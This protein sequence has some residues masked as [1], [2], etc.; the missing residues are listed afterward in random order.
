[1]DKAG[2]GPEVSS[3][4]AEGESLEVAVKGVAA[5]IGGKLKEVAGGLLGD[6]DL[7]REGVAQ[8]QEA[9][10]RRAGADS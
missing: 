3:E 10:S 2:D 9:E 4:D 7:E 8:Q 1:M 5:G 6:E